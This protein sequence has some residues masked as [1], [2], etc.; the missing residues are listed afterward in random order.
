MTLLARFFLRDCDSVGRRPRLVGRP[1]IENGGRIVLGD[2][3]HFSSCPVQSHFVV[4]G[5][6]LE[7]GSAVSIGQ[8]A[9]ISVYQHVR[10]GD[11][12]V[13]GAFSTIADTDFHVAGDRFAKPST[14]PILI[15]KHVRIGDRVTILRGTQIRDGAVIASGSVVAGNVDPHVRVAGVPARVAQAAG[16]GDARHTE[17]RLPEIVQRVLGLSE[18]PRLDQGP[19]AIDRWDSLGTLKLMLALE[20]EFQISLREDEVTRALCV[21]DLVTAVE[22]ARRQTT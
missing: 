12:T 4:R 7:I 21:A 5:G 14:A 22:A 2:D 16:S 19:D 13:L 9:A 11:G 10:I 15:G 3:V 17:E 18:R 6:S 20:E 1:W 8:G